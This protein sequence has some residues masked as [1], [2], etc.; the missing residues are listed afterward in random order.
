MAIKIF[1]SKSSGQDDHLTY[2]AERD[3]DDFAKEIMA[4]AR[5][6]GFFQTITDRPIFG[7][8]C[9]RDPKSL[10]EDQKDAL[11]VM[12]RIALGAKNDE[13]VTFRKGDF[14]ENKNG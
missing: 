13:T 4:P 9:V 2:F 6:N 11:A 3:N 1:L 14:G 7:E 12:A 8:S 5:T 10:T